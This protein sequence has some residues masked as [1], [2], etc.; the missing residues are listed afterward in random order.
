MRLDHGGTFPVLPDTLVV[1]FRRLHRHGEWGR[2]RIGAQPEIRAED[3]AVGRRFGHEL[4]Q[5]PG[6]TDEM[7]GKLLVVGQRGRAPVVEQ[8]QVDIAGIIEFAGTEFPHAEYGES[9]GLRVVADAELPVARKLQQD[10]VR[11][12][13][14]A[15]RC[16]GAERTGD[17][18]EGPGFGN[19][20]NADRESSTP[21]E[22]PKG[23]RDGY[24][25]SAGQSLAMGRRQL[26]HQV[27]EDY[28]RPLAP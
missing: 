8:D 5:E 15:A 7:A 21:F 4:D 27:A 18:V 17:T 26:R 25:F 23:H 13:G 6:A 10:G 16:K 28:V 2:A 22:A 9:R 19:V 1:E 11:K 20:G 14:E 12:R 24:R 3:V